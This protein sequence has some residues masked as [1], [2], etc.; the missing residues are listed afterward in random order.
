MTLQE[1]CQK[2]NYTESSV[3]HGFPRVKDYI[4]KTYGIEIIKVG[5]GKKAQYIEEDKNKETQIEKL[6]EFLEQNPYA[7]E[8]IENLNNK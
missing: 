5:K 6:Q 8:Y 7:K 2:Y 3:L 4:L 1:L